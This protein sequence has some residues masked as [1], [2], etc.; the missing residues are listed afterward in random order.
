MSYEPWY[1]FLENYKVIG[2]L[3]CKPFDTGLKRTTLFDPCFKVTDYAGDGSLFTS[4]VLSYSGTF[5]E[6]SL[7]IGYVEIKNYKFY[8][9]YKQASMNVIEC[10]LHLFSKDYSS[11]KTIEV[12]LSRQFNGFDRYSRTTFID[13]IN[14]LNIYIDNDNDIDLLNE[15]IFQ[16]NF[17]FVALDSLQ[18]LKSINRLNFKF[19][20]NDKNRV[21]KDVSYWMEVEISNLPQN[22]YLISLF[23]KILKTYKVIN[24]ICFQN[25]ILEAT[26]N[27]NKG[28][29]AYSGRREACDLDIAKIK[30]IQDYLKLYILTL[31]DPKQYLVGSLKMFDQKHSHSN[32]VS[33][34]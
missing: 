29:G 23:E 16:G 13:I 21:G 5:S 25:G 15:G 1:C 32:N 34:I 22:E 4:G 19:F 27:H 8:S 11:S 17:S 7:K 3:K 2:E 33:Q 30:E 28:W 9:Q 31:Y 10:S 20:S 14:I 18:I 6:H 12:K 26:Y 24:R